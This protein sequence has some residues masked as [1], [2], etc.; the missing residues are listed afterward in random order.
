VWETPTRLRS[1]ANIIEHA[2]AGVDMPPP[3]SVLEHFP[4]VPS[5]SD[6]REWQGASF[7]YSIAHS[8][9][10]ACVFACPPWPACVRP[11]HPEP[12]VLAARGLALAL[13]YLLP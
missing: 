4:P 7:L 1:D 3:L 13:A 2:D 11:R 10:V 9:K 6:S 5:T 12:A 8:S